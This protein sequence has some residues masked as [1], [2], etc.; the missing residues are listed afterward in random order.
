[1][2]GKYFIKSLDAPRDK[3]EHVIF[4]FSDGTTL[5][6]QDTRK[7]GTFDIYTN[8]ELKEKSPLL[9][10]GPEPGSITLTPTYLQRKLSGKSIAIKSALLDQTIISGLGNIYVNEVLFHSNI[11][12]ERPCYKVTKSEIKK[13]I[14]YSEQVIA[15]AI[16]LGGS[17]IRSYT[18]SLGVTG[19]FQNELFVH[20]REHQPC[21]ICNTDIHKIRVGGRGT[22]YCPTCQK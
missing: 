15:K 17:S 8:E 16:E 9:L 11:H 22:Y 12:P 14:K 7:F 19:R 6:Y 10:M 2:E 1:M 18:A 3:H 5:R 20:M 13:I 4:Y 21:L